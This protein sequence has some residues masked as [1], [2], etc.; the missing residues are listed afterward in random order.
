MGNTTK[1]Y[2]SFGDIVP[3]T[4][5]RI[6]VK[7]VPIYIVAGTV[8][9]G[10]T[11]IFFPGIGHK[12]RIKA[13]REACGGHV[14]AATTTLNIDDAGA[15]G[16]STTTIANKSAA[17]LATGVYVSTD[18]SN[19]ALAANRCVKVGFTIA[20]TLSNGYSI[21]MEYVDDITDLINV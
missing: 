20:H 5:D 16:A 10:L 12:V 19:Y 1:S 21:V 4:R 11:T 14:G 7:S 2:I 15:A 8:V 3:K 18:A 17:V 13:F 6:E 9:A